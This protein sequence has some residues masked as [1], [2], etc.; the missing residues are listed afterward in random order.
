MKSRKAEDSHYQK[1]KDKK[2]GWPLK[3]KLKKS[4]ETKDAA[5]T[6]DE[7]QKLAEDSLPRGAPGRQSFVYIPKQKKNFK[8]TEAKK[9]RKVHQYFMFIHLFF[10]CSV[11]I[12][13]HD[14][15]VSIMIGDVILAWLNFYNYMTLN[16]IVSGINGV[17]YIL[18]TIVAWTHL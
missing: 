1:V 12:F 17:M 5:L 16:K 8:R 15:E 6:F 7:I 3:L 14:W 9:L 4:E 11:D 13:V 18:G 2:S 10:L